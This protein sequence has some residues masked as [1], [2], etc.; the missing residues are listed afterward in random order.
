VTGAPEPATIRVRVDGRETRSV[1]VT[2]PTLYAL[3]DGK[4]YGEHALELEFDTPGL[5]LYSMTF[6]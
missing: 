4:A 6:G 3:V 2:W 5:A 1:E